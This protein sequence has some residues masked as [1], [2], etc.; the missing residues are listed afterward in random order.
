MDLVTTVAN[1][2]VISVVGLLLGWFAKGRFDALERRVDRMEESIQRAH[3][4][5]RSDL[6]QVA[7]VVGAQPRAEND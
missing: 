7:L 1:A 6:T 5:L 2:A 3:E 4:A